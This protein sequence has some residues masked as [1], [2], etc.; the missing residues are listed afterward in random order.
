MLAF[1]EPHLIKTKAPQ[2]R[3]EFKIDP[4]GTVDE[5]LD[6][7]FVSEDEKMWN[8]II[9]GLKELRYKESAHSS[10]KTQ[11]VLYFFRF[12]YIF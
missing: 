7:V 2:L 3:E 10:S 9:A 12:L 4:L 6:I 8:R 5:F 1:V 11:K